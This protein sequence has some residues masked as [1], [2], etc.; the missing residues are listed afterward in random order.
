MAGYVELHCKS[1][2]SFLRGASHPDELVQQAARLGYTGLALTDIDTLAGVVRGYGAAKHLAEEDDALAADQPLQYIVGAE[3]HPS[4]APPL[5]VWPS[6]R[7]AYGRLCQLISRGRLRAQKGQCL[8]HWADVCE[9]SQGLLAG[10][11]Q[12]ASWAN[13]GAQRQASDDGDQSIELTAE[14]LGGPFRDCFADRGYLLGSLHYGPD[15]RRVL[16]QLQMWSQQSAVPLVASGNVHYHHP[17]RMLMHDCVTAIRNGTTIDQVHSQ[18]LA[19]SQFHLKPL[20]EIQQLYAAAPGSMERTLEIASRCQ[21]CLSQLRYEYPSDL[22]PKGMTA[23]EHLKRLTWEGAKQR[24]PEHVPESVL[25]L[26]RHEIRLIEDLSYEAYFLTVWDIVRFARS[27]DILCQGRGSAANSVVCYCLGI[28]SVDP[29]QNDLLFER[30]ISRERNEAPD[31]DVDFEHQRR[32]EVLQYLYQKYG[33][34]RAGMTATVT[35]YRSKSA[36]R[37]V[38]KSLGLSNDM[39]D[40]F[41]KLV[42]HVSRSQPDEDGFT[43]RLDQCGL[44]IQSDIG[45]RFVYLVRSLMGFPRHLSQHV[46]GMVMSAGQL[47]ALCPLENAAMEGRT[48]IQWDKDDLDELGILKVD[49]LSL[50]MLSAL[51]RCFDLVA[52]HHQVSLSLSNLPPDDRPTYDM[53]CRADTVGV[54]QIE[55]RAQMSM[56]P[57]LR[58]RC[59]YDLVIEVAIVRPGPIQGDMVHPFLTAR[60]NPD[61]VVYPSDA[62][63]K[64]L[65]KTLGVPLFQEQAMRLAVVAAGFTPGEADQLRRAMAAWRRP[66]VIDKFREK[67]MKGMQANGLT[68]KFAEQVFHQIRAFGEYGFPESHAASFALLVYAS[69][70]LKCHYPA[71]FCCAL[72]NSQPLGFYAPAQLVADAKK[73]GVYIWPVN[74]NSSDLESTLEADPNRRQPGL[75]LGFQMVRGLP[76]ESAETI[77]AE[78]KRGGAYRSVNDLVQR[79]Q[80]RPAVLS[81]LAD[82]DVLSDLVG[83]RRAAIW[84]ALGQDDDPASSP[85]F[86]SIEDDEEIPDQLIAMSPS[87]ETHADYQTVGLSL[88]AHP[89]S[90]LRDDLQDQ[91]VTAAAELMQLRDGR[92]VRVAG[93]VLLRQRPSTAK[94]I[95]FVTL[96]DETGTVNLVIFPDTWDRFLRIAKTS[97]AWLVGGK[98][99]NRQGVI[100]VIVDHLTDLSDQV[101]QWRQRSR[102]FH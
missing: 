52:K 9:F 44:D 73:N 20:A 8:L 69:C 29:T 75:R 13:D 95:Y 47:S 82:A 101:G 16:Q 40:S 15:D 87:E 31:I 53:I 80:L 2:F 65:E 22:A 84:M 57:R 11:F 97:Q 46:G 33:R 34:D 100:H 1:N 26:L 6:D 24:W 28:T 5:V 86:S 17:E 7:E 42:G 21:F 66:G 30:F 77:V 3:I 83:D 94:G 18:R 67:L 62:I 81:L 45:Q 14:F 85:L 39:L 4:D 10:A 76:V 56:L 74:I 79:C 64:V 91:H 54:F 99:E 63:R 37:E 38:G 60:Q 51:H 78:R 71:A 36:M 19:N 70:Y 68:G 23:I 72:L 58:P 48:V 92:R 98:L 50:G 96:E 49:V 12:S 55:S 102:D 89:I 88:K 25:E 41:S 90:F 43:D 61:A 32:E 35:T 27:Q 93:L 59:F